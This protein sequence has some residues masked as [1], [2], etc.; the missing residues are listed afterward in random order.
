MAGK[1]HSTH[2][3]PKP[4]RPGRHQRA[5][6]LPRRLLCV[7]HPA[8]RQSTEDNCIFIPHVIATLQQSAPERRRVMG[9]VCA[10]R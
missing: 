2:Y 1:L 4:L 7:A 6:L 9:T 3:H 10:L 8:L 5:L